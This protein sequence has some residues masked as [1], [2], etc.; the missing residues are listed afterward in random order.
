MSDFSTLM[1]NVGSICASVYLLI[2]TVRLH[3]AG[4]WKGNYVAKFTMCNNLE[5]EHIIISSVYFEFRSGDALSE[6]AYTF[7]FPSP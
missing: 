5:S 3:T 4:N 2:I 6:A 1:L 7:F